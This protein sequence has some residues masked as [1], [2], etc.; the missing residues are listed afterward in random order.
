VIGGFLPLLFLA[1]VGYGIFR[2]LSGRRHPDT[3]ESVEG[4]TREL[5]IRAFRLALLAATVILVAEGIAAL[6]AI[7]IPRS[8]ELARDPLEI[9]QALSF[10]VV[11]VP[12]LAGLAWWTRRRLAEDPDEEPSIVW[13]AYLGGMVALALIMTLVSLYEVMDWLVGDAPLNHRALGRVVTWSAVLGVHWVLNR[14]RPLVDLNRRPDDRTPVY[15]LVGSAIGLGFAAFSVWEFLR[16]VLRPVYDTVFDTD[17]MAA[18]SEPI[19]VAAAHAVI[20]LAAWIWW[21]WLHGLRSN[22]DGRWYGYVLLAGVLSGLVATLSAG[23][24]MLHSVLQWVFGDPSADVA[25]VHFDV[26]PG[27]IAVLVVGVAV[28]MHHRHELDERGERVRTEV[29]RIYNYLVAFAGL[30]VSAVAVTLV[31][32]A[33]VEAVTESGAVSASTANPIVLAVT[34]LIL[35][36]PLWW[37]FWSRAERHAVA[38]PEE[39]LSISRRVYVIVTLGMSATVALI[40]LV[41]MLTIFFEDMA[42]GDLGG[43]TFRRLRVPLGLVLST[44]VVA[45]YHGLVYRDDRDAAPSPPPPSPAIHGVQHLVMVSDL[46]TENAGALARRLAG[47]TGSRTVHY[48]TGGDARPPDDDTVESALAALAEVPGRQALVTVSDGAVS[49]Q[50]LVD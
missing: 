2:L 33:F 36:L 27:S 48:R 1:L 10:T 14:R 18:G 11:G 46:S 17:V 9:A 38:D 30:V 4:D 25:A 7:A 37:L 12:A 20:G 39:L 40:S 50:G 34:F 22:R 16:A 47:S 29:D 24:V 15:L 31:V 6:I 5:V 8:G 49:V 19:V 3:G 35:G 28:W 32:S 45:V 21:W 26:L 13:A 42:G 43:E 44:A 41:I 23:G